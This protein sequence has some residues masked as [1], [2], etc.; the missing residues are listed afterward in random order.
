MFVV[1]IGSHLKVSHTDPRVCF[2]NELTKLSVRR[3]FHPRYIKSSRPNAGAQ[4][5][6]WKCWIEYLF[7]SVPHPTNM[8]ANS[9]HH[10][11]VQ[12]TLCK[13]F[14]K[15]LV[16]LLILST[17]YK[18]PCALCTVY[19]TLHT[20]HCPFHTVH[21]A[22]C[23]L[24]T[25]ICTH[26]ITVCN[27]HLIAH[28]KSYYFDFPK[29]SQQCVHY[30]WVLQPVNIPRVNIPRVNIPGWISQGP[31]EVPLDRTPCRSTLSSYVC[32]EKFTV[33]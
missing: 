6:F 2:G 27:V 9:F 12:W 26:C 17:G 22:H 4:S 5:F 25:V 1:G 24:H 10:L 31:F 23:K 32:S 20:V 14:A 33:V 19:C 13:Q 16:P 21:F 15:P 3:S 18:G 8:K 29:Y 11:A 7:S 30:P 28:Q